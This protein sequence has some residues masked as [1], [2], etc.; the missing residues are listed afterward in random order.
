MAIWGWETSV[1]DK[2]RWS[3]V[4]DTDQYAGNFERQLC[5]YVIGTVDEYG[6]SQAE[7]YLD[8][9]ESAMG[10]MGLAAL[11]ELSDCRVADPGDDGICLAPMD[12]APTPDRYNEG[13]GEHYLAPLGIAYQEPAYHSVAIFLQRE[14]TQDEITILTQRAKEFELLPKIKDWD[15]RPKILGCR[16]VSETV[17]LDVRQVWE[18]P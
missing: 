6:E 5:A 4:V 18:R 16:L 10:Y 14:P 15:S 12:L 9:F 8:S 13:K 11:K 17:L 1:V 2:P 7:F 3:F